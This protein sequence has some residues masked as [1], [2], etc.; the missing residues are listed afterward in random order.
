MG[1]RDGKGMAKWV[2][3]IQICLFKATSTVVGQD[4]ESMTPSR[5]PLGSQDEGKSSKGPIGRYMAMKTGTLSLDCPWGPD[6]EPPAPSHGWD[7]G[8][9]HLS[10]QTH[11][12]LS[13]TLLGP[14]TVPSLSP[15]REVK[16]W[17]GNQKARNLSLMLP[18]VWGTSDKM[19]LL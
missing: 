6:S 10:F 3:P 1:V 5:P 7:S 13:L 17:T 2:V 11:G 16:P 4:V 14:R 9:G 12:S 15:V 8:T 19:W 18:P